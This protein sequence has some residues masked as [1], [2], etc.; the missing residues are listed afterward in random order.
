[1]KVATRIVTREQLRPS[2]SSRPQTLPSQFL[3]EVIG[4]DGQVSM[5][6]GPLGAPDGPQ[7]SAPHLS[8]AGAPFTAPAAGAS[9]DSWR[10]LVQKLS[11]G[12]H[13]VI[14]YG[15]ADLDSTVTR[16]EI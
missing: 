6:G 8:D 4:T 11:G 14:A 7:L 15:L 16:L 9:G 12:D 2:D 13:L 3:V 5:A 10:V 1:S